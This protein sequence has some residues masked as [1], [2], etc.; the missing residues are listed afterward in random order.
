MRG[1]LIRWFPA[2]ACAGLVL[3]VAPPAS[4]SARPAQDPVPIRPNQHFTGLV[5]T[6]NVGPVTITVVCPAPTGFGHP[7]ADQPVEVEPV[8]AVPPLADVGFTGSRGASITAAITLNAA[9]API[10]VAHFTSYFV[11]IDIPTTIK[12]PCSGSA[13]M[14]FV[15]LPHSNTARTAALD[16]TFN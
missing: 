12:L 16:V 7:A 4:A 1:R 13:V 15:P 5:N 9:A 3:T 2:L 14:N 10:K 11:V 8:T 6:R